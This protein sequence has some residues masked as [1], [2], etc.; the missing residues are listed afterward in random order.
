MG[1]A[2]RRGGCTWGA[3]A[4]FDT[5]RSQGSADSASPDRSGSDADERTPQGFF[6]KRRRYAWFVGVVFIAVCI[7]AALNASHHVGASL[8]GPPPGT[9][10]PQFAAPSAA[11]NLTGDADVKQSSAQSASLGHAVA[12]TVRGPGV[13]NSCELA[14]RPLVLTFIATR[15]T[16]CAG[17]LDTIESVRHQFPDVNFAAV[18]TGDDLATVR[19]LAATHHTSFPIAVDRDGAVANLYQIGVC[20]TTVFEQTGGRVSAVDLGALSS[21]S[22]AQRAA[23]LAAGTLQG[24]P[25]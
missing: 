1:C 5:D 14:Q 16:A 9:V 22:L 18:V 25:R 2:R 13:V 12:C 7:V 10:A 21:P 6:G 11:G 20:P 24:R 17:Q 15:A 23:S 8:Y 3:R 19:S 4:V